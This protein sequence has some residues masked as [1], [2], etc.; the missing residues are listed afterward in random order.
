MDFE[1]ARRGC[2]AWIH[3][4]LGVGLCTR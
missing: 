2:V 3:V 1:E 4:D